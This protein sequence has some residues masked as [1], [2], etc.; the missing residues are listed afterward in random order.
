M[1]DAPLFWQG[2]VLPKGMLFLSMHHNPIS[3]H[4]E[5]APTQSVCR[6]SAARVCGMPPTAVGHAVVRV[7]SAT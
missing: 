5:Y 7:S 3:M 2:P 1:G 4:F 6:A